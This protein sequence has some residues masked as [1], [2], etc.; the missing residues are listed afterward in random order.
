[1]L[2]K[3]SRIRSQTE[4][5]IRARGYGPPGR[6]DIGRG[7]GGLNRE[8]SL[9][10]GQTIMLFFH[11]FQNQ[12][13]SLQKVMWPL[14][15]QLLLYDSIFFTGSFWRTIVS[16]WGNG[17]KNQ[18]PTRA[19]PSNS[20]NPWSYFSWKV[21]N[22]IQHHTIPD[23]TRQYHIIPDNTVQYHFIVLAPYS[24]I[25]IKGGL[26]VRNETFQELLSLL[27]FLSVQILL[28]H[29]KEIECCKVILFWGGWYCS[30]LLGGFVEV[31]Y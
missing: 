28:R 27:S 5:M 17:L 6:G 31:Q 1:M 23:I 24:N 4:G 26:F 10:M 21:Y 22:T 9:Q 16:L 13:G 3:I 20:H 7:L 30:I 14:P 2:C 18:R 11:G 8:A 19:K 12:I 29:C 25:V 15:C